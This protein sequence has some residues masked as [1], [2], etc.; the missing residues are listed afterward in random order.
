MTTVQLARASSVIANGGYLVQPRSLV[1]DRKVDPP[2][3]VIRAETAFTMRRMMEGVVLHGTG[4]KAQLDGYSTA[5]KPEPRR[6]SIWRRIATPT[7]TTRR[8]WASRP[9][10]TRPS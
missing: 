6:S 8:S 9:F 10:R 1:A 5:G 7:S 4:R 2:Q 3:R